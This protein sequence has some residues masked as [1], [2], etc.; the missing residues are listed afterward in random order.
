MSRSERIDEADPVDN[1]T[2]LQILSEKVAHISSDIR[3]WTL[4]D[5]WNW[6][7]CH[8]DAATAG[9]AAAFCR[10]PLRRFSRS[11]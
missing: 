5:V 9:S 7:R 3:N 4:F 2:V 8:A 1:T 10:R 6:T 11:R